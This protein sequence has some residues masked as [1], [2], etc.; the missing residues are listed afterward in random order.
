MARKK[1]PRGRPSALTPEVEAAMLA[2]LRQGIPLVIAA[3]ANGV[4]R[5][6][7]NGWVLRGE[8]PDAP[9]HDFYA[10]FSDA[11]MRAKAQ[12]AAYL[13]GLVF[14]AARGDRKAKRKKNADGTPA[15]IKSRMSPMRV[16]SA[17]WLLARR[18]PA[19]Y[20]SFLDS[21]VAT[22]TDGTTSS[23]GPR[24][25]V[26]VILADTKKAEQAT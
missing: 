2:M 25:L 17:Q 3:E 8:D 15:T 14:E 1:K 11:Y 26:N 10:P 21:T 4:H 16:A 19:H 22:E 18:F 23:S 12:G 7:V 24:V 9:N 5:D 20:G 6:T 13:H